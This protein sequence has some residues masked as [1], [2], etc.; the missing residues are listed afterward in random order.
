M[1]MQTGRAR[2][3][4]LGKLDSSEGSDNS[5]DESDYTSEAQPEGKGGDEEDCDYDEESAEDSGVPDAGGEH[6]SNEESDSTTGKPVDQEGADETDVPDETEGDTDSGEPESDPT[7]DTS[8]AAEPDEVE[9]DEPI[10]TGADDGQGGTEVIENKEYDDLPMGTP[11]ETKA[12]L[13][14]WGDH[15]EKPKTIEEDEERELDG[16]CYRS[17]LVL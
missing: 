6:D 8:E 7:S 16:Y 9:G 12:A 14:T 15:E 17:G 1:E 3:M 4:T 2:M 13:L 5:N 11:E 10:D